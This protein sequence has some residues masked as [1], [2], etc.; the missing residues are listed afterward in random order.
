[1]RAI[2]GPGDVAVLVPQ[3]VACLFRVVAVHRRAVAQAVE[4]RQPKLLPWDLVRD[5]PAGFTD[6]QMTVVVMLEQL[7][8]RRLA[9]G[10]ARLLLRAVERSK[11]VALTQR[12]AGA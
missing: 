10:R 9:G 12:A 4:V 5:E 7:G 8:E 6:D 11:D 3:K 1:M 2:D